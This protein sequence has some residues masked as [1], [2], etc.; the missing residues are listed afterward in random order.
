MR[1]KGKSET[2]EIVDCYQGIAIKF[3][4]VIIIM[5]LYFYKNKNSPLF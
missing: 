1:Q 5:S 2:A 4:D 3:L